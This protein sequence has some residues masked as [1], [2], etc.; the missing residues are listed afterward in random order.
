MLDNAKRFHFVGIG[1]SG[2]SGIAEILLSE[3]CQVTG[4]DI[5]D[6]AAV[7]RLRKLGAEVRIGHAAENLGA[8]DAAVVS[9][10]IPESN[11]EVRE[12]LSRGVP[13]VERAEML[14]E[15]M[16][17]KYNVAVSG[18][19]GKTTT[20][21]LIGAVMERSGLDPTVV[22]G[23]CFAHLDSG[24]RIGKSGYFL[25]EADEAYGSVKRFHP[26][27]AVVTSV[28]ADHLDYYKDVDE[29]G[30][31]LAAFSNRVPRSG[32]SVWC[33]DSAVS[34][35]LL[36]QIRGRLQTYGFWSGADM[37]AVDASYCGGSSQFTAEL[38]GEKLGVV[39]LPL[40]GA[41]N[42]LNALAAV[43]A[44][45][46]LGAAF[47]AVAEALEQF[48]GVRRRFEALGEEGGVLIVDDYAHN[49][50]KLKAV[51]NGVKTG[52]PGR[53]LVTVFQPHRYHRVQSL[54]NEFSRSFGQTDVL[55]VTEIY[56]AGETPI[57]GVTGA[58][59]ADQIRRVGHPEVSFT[60]DRDDLLA[61][62]RRL[63][64]P[65]DIVLTVGAGDISTVGPDLL[66][67]LRRR[68]APGGT[69][70]KAAEEAP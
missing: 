6:S 17:G 61:E 10:I 20:T 8:A 15:L 51:F 50:A 26:S 59:L 11:P 4:S 14:A 27:L 55:L 29:I 39:R 34:R 2:M 21:A 64:R 38:H 31:T 53:R 58:G 24:V 5:S 30:Q 65:G 33:A 68:G 60:P 70:S 25:A 49:P 66:A 35:N 18:T 42:V 16:R 67:S 3:G 7:A 37:R 41:Y 47:P 19:H 52:Y 40:P 12:A 69:A 43:C 62:L 13:V 9:S 45:L 57:E 46:E 22:N 63:A 48:Q 32:L 54:A 44:G 36:P 56:G 1:G 23:G 28:D